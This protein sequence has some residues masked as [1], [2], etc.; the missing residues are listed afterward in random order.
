MERRTF[1]RR[2]FKSPN[3]TRVKF[4]FQRDDLLKA[5]EQEGIEEKIIELSKLNIGVPELNEE[6]QFRPHVEC[7]KSSVSV[8]SMNDYTIKKK[9]FFKQ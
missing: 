9:P 3:I 4:N 5:T 6:I 7:V 2:V 1:L 8:P